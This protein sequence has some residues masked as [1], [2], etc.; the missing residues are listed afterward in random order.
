VFSPA[1]A[2][3]KVFW[4][5]YARFWQAS[6]ANVHILINASRAEFPCNVHYSTNF[7]FAGRLIFVADRSMVTTS[8][9]LLVILR[10]GPSCGVGREVQWVA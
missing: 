8:G 3:D 6:S 7:R 10:S 4:G 1:A 2:R 5:S 9:W